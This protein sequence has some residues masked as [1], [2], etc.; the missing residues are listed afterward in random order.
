[1][2]IGGGRGDVPHVMMSAELSSPIA[3]S[4][5]RHGGPRPVQRLCP[6][7]LSYPPS[8]GGA[9]PCTRAEVL[10]A[11]K[12][13]TRPLQAA[14]DTADAESGEPASGVAE[15][16]R[17]RNSGGGSLRRLPRVVLGGVDLRPRSVG[18]S[19]PYDHAR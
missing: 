6:G 3:D 8:T 13:A 15:Y 11:A 4:G 17:S 16:E 19:R 12:T 5:A 2:T 18:L 1:V 14:L 7:V 10:A 9:V